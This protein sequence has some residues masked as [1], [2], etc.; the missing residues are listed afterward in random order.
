[1][2]S[3]PRQ[4]GVKV[5]VWTLALVAA[6]GVN[7]WLAR[8]TLSS[9]DIENFNLHGQGNDLSC[10]Q[11]S[12]SRGYEPVPGTCGLDNDGARVFRDRS[13]GSVPPTRIMLLGDSVAAQP[14][15]PRALRE[16]L[17]T[18]WPGAPVE[19]HA[20]GVAGYNLCQELSMYREKVAS[21]NP[22]LV[23]LQVSGN[24]AR[25]SPVLMHVGDDI[26]YFIGS[27]FVEFPGWVLES[28]FLTLA[29]VSFLPRRATDFD[30]ERDG[31]ARACLVSLRDE[32]EARNIP[33]LS[34]F[35]PL[36]W[37]DDEV[38][39][40]FRQDELTVRAI[41]DDVGTKSFD[42]RPVLEAAGPMSSHRSVPSDFMHPNDATQLV[43]GEAFAAWIARQTPDPAGMR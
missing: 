8:R 21:V 43:V 28:R 20:Y 42:L 34:I 14:V 18:A 23:L 16:H 2:H 6:A 27:E 10:V 39:P 17:Q 22:D 40:V 29:A 36:L 1:M 35:F 32:V 30:S 25:Q 41:H 31:Y 24:D 7:E 13:S 9:F 5:A 12:L 37:E 11:P 4:R 15:W 26:R 19:V 33:F 38:P 3:S